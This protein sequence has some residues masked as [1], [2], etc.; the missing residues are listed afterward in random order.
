MTIGGIQAS[1]AGGGW[2]LMRVL[3]TSTSGQGHVQPL[4]GLVRAF[5]A[6]GDDNLLVLAAEAVPSL[7]DAGLHVIAGNEP[8]ERDRERLWT[9]FGELPRSEA[10]PLVE[11]DWFAGL[12]LEA[13]LPSVDAAVREWRPDLLVRETCEYAGAVVADRVGIPQVQHGISTAAAEWGG[14]RA[15]ARDAL[16]AHAAGLTQRVEGSPYV[17]RFPASLDP[18]DYPRTLRYRDQGNTS[19]ELT[20]WWHGSRAPL[21]YVTLGTVATSTPGGVAVL[22]QVLDTVSQLD[23]RVLATT[24][25]SLAP[26]AIG[27]VAPNV[28]VEAWVRQEDIFPDAALVVCHGGSGTTFGALAAGVPLVMLPMFADQPTNAR[29]VEKAGAG[30]AVAGGTASATENANT[31]LSLRYTL[32]DAVVTVLRTSRYRDAARALA[33]EIAAVPTVSELCETLAALGR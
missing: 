20:D 21:V 31:L 1:G 14:L 12:C 29:L 19:R 17:T 9:R 3:F 27:D 13:M 26:D 6:R 28:H 24:G 32:R 8:D 30:I 11:R 16:D 2:R 22:R 4:L 25:P 15:F 18:S 5:N 10:T 33:N 7:A 23:V